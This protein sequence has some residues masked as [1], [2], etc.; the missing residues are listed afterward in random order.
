M[1]IRLS[2]TPCFF[3]GDLHRESCRVKGLNI[4]DFSNRCRIILIHKFF[5]KRFFKILHVPCTLESQG[6]GF[7]LKFRAVLCIQVL[8]QFRSVKQ[9]CSSGRGYIY[10]ME[11]ANFLT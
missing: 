10:S 4:Q 6:K 11:G 7:V 2:L 8:I 3:K 1:I 9:K 5:L